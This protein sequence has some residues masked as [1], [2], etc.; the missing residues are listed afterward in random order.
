MFFGGKYGD[1]GG[2]QSSVGFD[3]R[4]VLV[5]TLNSRVFVQFVVGISVLSLVFGYEKS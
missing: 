5:W 2:E 3:F 1:F 4:L